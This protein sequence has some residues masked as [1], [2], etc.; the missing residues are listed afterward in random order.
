MPKFPPPPPENYYPQK[1]SRSIGPNDGAAFS[2]PF[3]GLSSPRRPRHNSW[4]I[5][6]Y[7]LISAL[8]HINCN[9]ISAYNDQ[10]HII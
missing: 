8:E 7:I 3:F 1:C 9:E 6:Y 10:P 5:D 4:P 2:L